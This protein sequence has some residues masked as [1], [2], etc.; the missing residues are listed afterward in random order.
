MAATQRI[1]KLTTILAADAAG[2]SRLMGQD[3][4]A[5]VD[6][7]TAHRRIIDDLIEKRHGAIVTTAGDSVIVEFASV[8]D[9]VEC[10]VD[11][12][13]AIADVNKAVPPSRQMQFREG[14]NL[15]DVLVEGGTLHGDG[16]NVAVRIESLAEPGSVWISGAVRDQIWNKLPYVLEDKGEHELKNISYPVRVYKVHRDRLVA[17]GSDVAIRPTV[18]GFHS[19]PAIAVLPFANFSNDPDQEYFADGIT[20]DILTEL[21]AWRVFPVIA[22]NTTYTYKGQAV[23]IKAIGRKLGAR[24]VLEGSVRKM[25]DAVRVTAQLI[26][27]DSGHHL[28]A[29]RFDR[30]FADV[31]S[32]QNDIVLSVVGALEPELLKVERNRIASLPHQASD[33]YDCFMRGL[34]HHYKYTREDNA[35]AQEYFR[36][37]LAMDAN[38]VQSL[39]GLVSSMLYS[40]R[41]GWRDDTDHNFEL[42]YELAQRAVSADNRDPSAHFVLGAACMHTRRTELGMSAIREAIRLNPSF[43]AA[44]VFMGAF[45][46]HMNQAEEALQEIELAIRLSPYDGRLPIWLPVLAASQYLSGRYEAALTSGRRALAMQ[47]TMF[48]PWLYIA[49]SLGQL[50]RKDEAAAAIAELGKHLKDIVDVREFLGRWYRAAACIDRF[51]TGLREA[52]MA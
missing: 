25:G 22:R 28:F 46:N 36:Q 30:K 4:E 41:R 14:I 8:V 20:E 27:A 52:G 10:A 33:A 32:L 51:E 49:A 17:P 7:L 40:L 37:A 34:W 50:G 23:D 18:P 13:A 24:Y 5:T 19:R 44:H 29:E 11:I 38:N 39:T 2:Y 43:A 1:R 3:E 6:T 12:Q 35:K 48:E 26:D 42:A 9:A 31:I 15:G 47:S 16:V 21:A 45:L